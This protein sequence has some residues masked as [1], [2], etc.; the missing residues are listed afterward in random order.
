MGSISPSTTLDFYSSPHLAEHYDLLCA[1]EGAFFTDINVFY[2]ELR[3]VY[4][5]RINHDLAES[6]PE[7]KDEYAQSLAV[8]DVGTGTGRALFELIQRTRTAS[9]PMNLTCAHFL[10][11]DLSPHMVARAARTRNLAAA[12]IG[13]LDWRCASALKLDAVLAESGLS[14]GQVDLLIFAD[15]GFLHLET[16][17]QARQFLSLVARALRARSG[18][19]VLAITNQASVQEGTDLSYH[20]AS[21]EKVQEYS[22]VE[23]PGLVYR[24][25]LAG[26]HQDG[27]VQESTYQFEVWR[28]RKGE[29]DE[30]VESCWTKLKGRAWSD[31]EV[32]ALITACP[33]LKLIETAQPDRLQTFFIVSAE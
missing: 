4:D 33:G 2:K 32:Q 26:F 5:R 29:E 17:A 22:S 8:V 1:H 7:K 11:F 14:D 27:A 21:G 24:N 3:G 31:A 30:L 25:R 23:F 28:R 16:E 12:A 6:Q 10:G 18:R 20:D 13:K 15:G 9:P 19:A